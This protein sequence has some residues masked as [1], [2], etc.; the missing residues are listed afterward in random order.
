MARSK[1]EAEATLQALEVA[2]GAMGGEAH[3]EAQQVGQPD[4]RK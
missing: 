2:Q 4:V 1:E 3:T